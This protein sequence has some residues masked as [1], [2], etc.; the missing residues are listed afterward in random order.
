MTA[1]VVVIGSGG[2][3]AATAYFLARRGGGRRLVVLD[4]HEVASQTSPRAAGNAAVLGSTD[5]MTRLAR[6]AADWLLRFSE[7]TGRPLEI[8]RSS[9]LKAARRPEDAATL[10]E[11]AAGGQ[12]LGL[13]TRIV[14][15]YRT[16]EG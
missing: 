4:P 9:S 12:R 13:E 1:D 11:E 15:S 7:D 16:R 14:Y 3:G 6:R 10:D 2:L 8:V 5:V